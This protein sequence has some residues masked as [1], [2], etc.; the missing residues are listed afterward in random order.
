[1]GKL[2]P[3]LIGSLDDAILVAMAPWTLEHR[4][5][6]IENYFKS[7]ESVVAVQRLFRRQFNVK[8]HGNI[9]DRNTIFR[10]VEALRTTG[11]V[12]KRKPPV[13]VRTPENV[14]RVR[15]AVLRNPRHSAR[16]QALALR[17]SDWSVRR[18]LHKD[19]YFH[20]Y[21]I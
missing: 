2:R 12:M 14:E 10:W 19:L 11:S 5:F 4:E 21:K 20:P 9:P 1:V 7:N 15:L 13:S 18:I 17:M 6:V 16:R 3:L 8:H